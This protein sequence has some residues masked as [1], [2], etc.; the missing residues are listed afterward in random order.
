[1][2]TVVENNQIDAHEINRKEKKKNSRYS[3]FGVFG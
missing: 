3:F 2:A 1:V